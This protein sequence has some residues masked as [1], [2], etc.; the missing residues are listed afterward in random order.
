MAGVD[1]VLER[2]ITDLG[3]RRWLREDP[4]AALQGYDLDEADLELLASQLDDSGAQAHGVEQR[5]SKSALFG[6]LAGLQEPSAA[7]IDRPSSGRIYQSWVTVQNSSRDVPSELVSEVEQGAPVADELG[8]TGDLRDGTSST[9]GE[10]QSP[11]RHARLV[12]YGEHVEGA[13]SDGES[14]SD[15]VTSPWMATKQVDSADPSG[16]ELSASEPEAEPAA[17][18]TAESESE[19]P[20]AAE[21]G[22]FNWDFLQNKKT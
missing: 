18:V 13:V 6:L 22:R 10:T 9:A 11:R 21:E 20:A 17:E 3:F 14:V 19:P 1:E 12:D 8:K 7:D 15:R 5:T 4:A 2:L 16:S